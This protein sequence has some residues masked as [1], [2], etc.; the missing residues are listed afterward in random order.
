M[1]L[2]A[3]PPFSLPKVFDQVD[4]AIDA[5]AELAEAILNVA[6]PSFG[7]SEDD[8]SWKGK[9]TP[10]DMDKARST[11]RQFYRDWSAEGVPERY[12]CHLP[13]VSALATHLPL[14]PAK[15]HQL[16]VLVP[17]AGLGRLVFNLCNEGYTVQ[18]NEISYHQ[19]FAS[20]Y[21]LN[22]TRTTGQHI[23][24]PWALHF[25]NHAERAAQLRS[26]SIPDV[27]PGHEL[28]KSMQS[29]QS[30]VHYSERMSMTAGDFCETYRRPQ[31]KDGFNAVTTCFF[32]DTAANLIAYIETVMHCLESGG[33]WIN[34]GPLL[35]HFEPTSAPAEKDDAREGQNTHAAPSSRGAAEHGSFELSNEEVVA[36]VQKLGFD[37][38]E[39]K[40]APAGAVGY[41]QDPGSMLQN[42]YRPSFWVAKKR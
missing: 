36:L 11:L 17:G 25:S 34:L 2:L 24:Y 14:P 6:L 26:V 18:G 42:V 32:I 29:T 3:E 8:D 21:I 41:I 10:N 33:V 28:E 4:D 30:E 19:L 23:L 9:A 39:Q 38:L 5:N 7:F 12:A 1:D 22:C 27:H 35:W 15:R 31:C 16:R 20:N 40:L 37:V 13:I